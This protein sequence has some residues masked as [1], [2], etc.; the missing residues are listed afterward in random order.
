MR[1]L[2]LPAAALLGQGA[3]DDRVTDIASAP[4]TVSRKSAHRS[5]VTPSGLPFTTSDCA[6]LRRLSRL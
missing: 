2:G 5:L 3:A 4:P 6:S 1:L